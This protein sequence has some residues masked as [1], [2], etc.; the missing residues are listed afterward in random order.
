AAV[1]GDPPVG[2][3]KPADR[4]R[5]RRATPA[6]AGPRARARACAHRPDSRLAAS[7]CP[8]DDLLLLIPASRRKGPVDDS[9]AVAAV[10]SAPTVRVKR[11]RCPARDGPCEVRSACLA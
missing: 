1:S 2:P 10:G 8:L 4:T 5:P 3:G 6:G 9:A 7:E 11:R